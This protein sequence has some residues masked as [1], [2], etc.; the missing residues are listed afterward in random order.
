[1]SGEPFLFILYYDDESLH[2]QILHRPRGRHTRQ[3]LAV[4]QLLE[5]HF[6]SLLQLLVNAGL[7]LDGV[8][9]DEDVRV[10][11]VVLHNPLAGLGVVVGEEGHADVRTVHVGQGAAVALKLQGKRSPSEAEY[12][13]ISKIF[14]PYCVASGMVPVL[15]ETRDMVM[16]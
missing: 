10:N 11:T 5:G 9:V 3:R 14:G 6:D 4:L 15:V 16:R 13:L 7:L 8:V 2:S 1:M 12:L